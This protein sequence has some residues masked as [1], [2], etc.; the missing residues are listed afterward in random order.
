MILLLI[1]GLI[2]LIFPGWLIACCGLGSRLEEESCLVW[3]FRILGGVFVG[4]SV[5][6]FLSNVLSHS[7]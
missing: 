5:W 3:F 1:F 7:R 6:M 2:G 4:I